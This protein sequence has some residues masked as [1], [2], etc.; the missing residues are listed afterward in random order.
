MNKVTSGIKQAL[1]RRILLELPPK[2][3]G[4]L[5]HRAKYLKPIWTS[6]GACNFEQFDFLIVDFETATSDLRQRRGRIAQCR[7]SAAPCHNCRQ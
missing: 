6:S 1:S 3:R 2:V 5:V 7:A 4:L